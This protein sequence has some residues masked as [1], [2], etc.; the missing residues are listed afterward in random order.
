MKLTPRQ[1]VAQLCLCETT[2]RRGIAPVWGTARLLEK[3]S[4]DMGYRSDSLAIL[5]DMG[6][7]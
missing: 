5:R 3:V 2:P 4:R 7:H 1:G 6:G